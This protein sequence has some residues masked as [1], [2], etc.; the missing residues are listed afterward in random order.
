[1]SAGVIVARER[2][3]L[4]SALR[5][6]VRRALDVVRRPAERHAV[7]SMIA[8]S[9]GGDRAIRDSRR[10]YEIIATSPLPMDAAREFIRSHTFPSDYL[11]F[12]EERFAEQ[13]SFFAWAADRLDEGF[14]VLDI[15]TMPYTTSV[16]K[17]YRPDIAL[18]T[19]DMP[20]SLGGPPPS[21]FSEL[22][23]EKH[24]EVDLN[25]VSL[26]DLHG[27]VTAGG[28]FDLVY[29]CEIVEHLRL[30]AE[31][32][33]GFCARCLKPGGLVIVTT[34]NF[35]SEWKLHR[36][37]DGYNPS[38]RFNDHNP[39][40]GSFH[41]RE[42]TMRELREITTSFGAHVV[43]EIFSWSLL[44]DATARASDEKARFRENM[45]FL[46]SDRPVSL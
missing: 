39:D 5:R 31:A 25:R 34:P 33:L 6:L 43:G 44:D 4:E 10:Y 18:V 29:A 7:A 12:H 26:G 17:Y 45:V 15:S 24:V 35:H 8:P 2:S 19:V 9:G 23:V 37:R 20:E 32:F 1:M 36:M 21:R 13:L 28:L 41:Y 42:Y 30:D 27:D 11:D 14:R 40:D 22:G 46:F 3:R 38:Q 16:M